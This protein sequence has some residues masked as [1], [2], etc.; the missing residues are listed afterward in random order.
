MEAR[1]RQRQRFKIFPPHRGA[2]RI[3]MYVVAPQT[4]AARRDGRGEMGQRIW[5]QD[6]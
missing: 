4:G 2:A 5:T 6:S 3:G 1:E